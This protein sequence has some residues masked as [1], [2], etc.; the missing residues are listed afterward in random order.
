MYL[1]VT[2][3]S[4]TFHFRYHFFLQIKQDISKGKLEVPLKIGVDLTAYSLQC[5]FLYLF[6]G[7]NFG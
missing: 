2:A 1:G 5:K 6:K 4:S 7:Q 3:I